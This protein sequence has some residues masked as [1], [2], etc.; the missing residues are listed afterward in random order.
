MDLGLDTGKKTKGKS[1]STSAEVLNELKDAHPIINYILEYRQ[2][3]KLYSTYIEGIEQA[4]FKDSK[5]HTIYAQALTATGRLS[6][7]EPNLQ[8]IPIRTE[9]GR[10][11]RKFFKADNKAI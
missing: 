2:L 5:V 6:S 10:Q 4:L 7:L 8:N 3:T 9:E 1:F 11:I